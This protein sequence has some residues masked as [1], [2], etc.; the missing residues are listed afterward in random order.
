MKH[1]SLTA[2]DSATISFSSTI[3]SSIGGLPA[4]SLI[5]KFGPNYAIA[6]AS[7]FVFIGYYAIYQIYL[8][9]IS[10]VVYLSIAMSLVGLGSI[11][12]FYACLKS[13]QSNFP[14]HRGSASIAPVGSYGMSATL[15]SIIT[16]I[17]F[18][19][20]TGGLLQFLAFSCGLTIFIGSFFI[21]IYEPEEITNQIVYTPPSTASTI[22]FTS[23]SPS[24]NLKLNNFD[25]SNRNPDLTYSTDTTPLVS[26]S[27]S[28]ADV[29]KLQNQPET[30]SADQVVDSIA[31]PFTYELGR[32]FQ[33]ETSS[34]NNLAFQNLSSNTQTTSKSLDKTIDVIKRRLSDK[35]YLVHFLVVSLI[36]GICQMYI[37]SIGYMVSAQL[38]FKYKHHPNDQERDHLI[39]KSQALQV[40]I[41]SISSFSGRVIGGL[42]SDFIH[43]KFKLQRSWVVIGTCVTLSI[44]QLASAFNVSNSATLTIGSVIVGGSYGLTFGTYPAVIADRYGTKTFST[45]WGLICTGPMF[46]LLFLD[47]IFGYIYDSNSHN[48]V[49]LKAN[50]CYK[51]VFELSFL[52]CYLALTLLGL[53]VL[54]ENK[55]QTMIDMQIV[56]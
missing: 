6:L 42:L 37:Y 23:T 47:K 33:S 8:H 18:H 27:Q 19:G 55:K 10:S 2:S 22:P 39:L 36:S 25:F 56:H 45:T 12:S 17:F 1:V 34:Q 11:T 49:C 53:S 43:K 14:K 4:G 44:G 50:D 20:N 32:E 52:L 38:N 15:F 16:A 46:S 28:F 30:T 13:S 48:G 54:K 51:G 35:T 21:N 26:R 3:G 5:D 31:A 40:G 24:N 41:I 29:S 7:I 9:K